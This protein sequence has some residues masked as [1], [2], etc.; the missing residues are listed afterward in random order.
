MF[1]HE[2]S[3]FAI[4]RYHQSKNLNRIPNLNYFDFIID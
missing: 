1:Q 4:L 3:N 2:T